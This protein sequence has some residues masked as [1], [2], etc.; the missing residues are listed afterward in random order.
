MRVFLLTRWVIFAGSF[1]IWKK[2][3]PSFWVVAF[4]VVIT[5]SLLFKCS[6]AG[7]K[8]FKNK[9]ENIFKW[10]TTI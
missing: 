7:K 1:N 10:M 9:L 3:T 4:Y 6:K 2:K 5:P 8:D